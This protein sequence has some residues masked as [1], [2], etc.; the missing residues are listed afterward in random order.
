MC[1]WRKL[2]Q[3]V[4][5]LPKGP[6]QERLRMCK[7]WKNWWDG[8][9]HHNLNYSKQTIVVKDLQNSHTL[10]C[11]SSSSFKWVVARPTKQKQSSFQTSQSPEYNHDE[12]VRSEPGLWINLL[13][14]RQLGRILIVLSA[15]V[16]IVTFPW[17]SLSFAHITNLLSILS[18]Q[19]PFFSRLNRQPLLRCGG[20]GTAYHH[21]IFYYQF[22]M[23]MDA[24]TQIVNCCSSNK[25]K[26]K[27]QQNFLPQIIY[28]QNI[29]S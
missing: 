9:F 24:A 13:T 29:K 10:S 17:L 19:S 4:S 7:R 12:L 18:R 28:R 25:A 11:C 21:L 3:E 8:N 6:R 16:L 2:C 15:N 1:P 22:S 23:V 14:N 27:V 20:I 5:L 26:L